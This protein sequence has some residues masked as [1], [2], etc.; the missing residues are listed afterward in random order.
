MKNNNLIAASLL[1]ALTSTVAYSAAT[2]YELLLSGPVE[3]VDHSTNSITVLGHRLVVRDA[4]TIAL[5]HTVNVFGELQ[6]GFSKAAIVEDTNVF[7]AGAERIVLIGTVRAID[8]L[9]GHVMIDGTK[10]D[11]TGLLAQSYFS[12]PAIGETVRVLGTQPSGRGLVL[13]GA[14]VGI[15]SA[16]VSSGGAPMGVSSGGAPMGVSSGGAPAA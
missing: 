1:L 5:G 4:S 10:V 6:N 12:I 15:G 8:K 9:R 16:G 11:Y 2:Q 7:A 14:I 13:A 3:A